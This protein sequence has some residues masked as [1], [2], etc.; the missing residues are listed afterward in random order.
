VLHSPS[1]AKLAP[2]LALVQESM[3]P[4]V[5]D[6]ANAH[7]KFKYAT[8]DA[9]MEA[10]RA[11]LAKAGL[12]VVQGG[13]IREGGSTL[14]EVE[15]LLIHTSGEWVANYTTVP[16]AKADP[17]G[18]GAALTYGRRY[19]MSA[20]LVLAT[21]DDNDAEPRGNAAPAKSEFVAPKT[22]PKASKTQIADIGAL[23]SV[24]IA[25]GTPSDEIEKW[26]LNAF[27]TVSASE[28]TRENAD[29]CLAKLRERTA[30]VPA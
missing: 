17:Q 1:L 2:A 27:G 21:E 8:L 22:P 18:M 4:V 20:L 30:K 12:V 13:R 19:G 10:V 15:T 11:P 6:R 23:T 28:M 9:I 24:L 7:F 26:M 25:D 3:E 5:K 14:L 29:R 16:I